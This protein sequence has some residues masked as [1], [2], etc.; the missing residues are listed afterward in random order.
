MNIGCYF[1]SLL[2]QLKENGEGRKKTQD[3]FFQ[4]QISTLWSLDHCLD[5][6]IFSHAEREERFITPPIFH[7]SLNN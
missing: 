7:E 5:G 4:G 1:I 3:E 2:W 6:F